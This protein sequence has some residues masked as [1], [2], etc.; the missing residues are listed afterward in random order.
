M[1]KLGIAAERLTKALNAL[2]EGL[3]PLD[4]VRDDAADL[5]AQLAEARAKLDTADQERERLLARIAE[6][7]EEQLALTQIS[8]EIEARLDGAIGEI[9]TALGR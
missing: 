9:R 6:L 8:E 2:E 4:R 7:E 5:R 1:D 3:V